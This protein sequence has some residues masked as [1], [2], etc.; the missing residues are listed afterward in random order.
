MSHTTNFHIIEQLPHPEQHKTDCLVIGLVEKK[1]LNPVAKQIDKASGGMISALLKKGEFEGKLGQTLCLHNVPGIK[2]ERLLLVGCGDNNKYRNIIESIIQAVI[3]TKAS[4]L[5]LC[6]SDFAQEDIYSAIRSAIEMTYQ[7]FYNFDQYKTENLK[8]RPALKSI[9][10]ALPKPLLAATLALAKTAIQHG[11]ALSEAIH[12]TKDLGNTPPNICTPSYLA[13]YAKKLAKTYKKLKVSVLE[14]KEISKLK[15]GLLLSV[16]QGS[17]E[18]PKFIIINYKGNP[19]KNA[20]KPIVLVGKGI[21]FDTGGNSLKPAAAMMGMKYD[22]CGA[23]TVLGVLEFAT[24]VNLPI[25]IVG[26]IPTCENMPGGSASRPDDIVTSMSGLTVEILNTDAEGRLILADA[27][28]YAE[29]F[30]PKAVIDI[31][32]LTGACVAA[33]GHHASGLL[34]NDGALVKSL[35]E[36]GTKSHDR[37]WELPLWPEYESILSSKFADIANANAASSPN[38]GTITGACFLSKFTKKYPW[39]HL[40]V[41]GSACYFGGEQKGATGRPVSLLAQYLLN[42]IKTK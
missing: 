32:T 18:P 36:A 37:A 28:T 19:S 30:H 22:M 11:V 15:M 33:L 39:A 9:S 3:R 41:A 31:A 13:N 10:F 4:N 42:Q 5:V 20:Q 16:T 24:R 2:A 1:V 34:G 25:N 6:L 7:V 14:K 23:A 17:V 27:L 38:A 12:H 40:D 8:K 21:T 26:L 35:L 29:R